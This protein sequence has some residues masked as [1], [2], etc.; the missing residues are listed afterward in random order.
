[1]QHITRK[2]IFIDDYLEKE[3]INLLSKTY[4]IKNGHKSFSEVETEN[5][6]LF[7]FFLRAYSYISVKKNISNI[8]KILDEDLA[9]FLHKELMLDNVFLFNETLVKVFAFIEGNTTINIIQNWKYIYLKRVSNIHGIKDAKLNSN[10]SIINKLIQNYKDRADKEL[11]KYNKKAKYRNEEYLYLIFSYIN[12][13]FNI[14]VLEP[15][16]SEYISYKIANKKISVTQEYEE[17]HKLFVMHNAKL[18]EIDIENE[19]ELRFQEV[20]PFLSRIHRQYEINGNIIDILGFDDR[21]GDIYIIEIKNKN[22]PKDLLFQLKNYK[23]AISKEFKN[24][25]IKLISVTPKLEQDYIRELNEIDVEMYFFKKEE[26][27][28]IF[29]KY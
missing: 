4:D 11:K 5:N 3:Y 21:E 13:D 28:I 14:K 2:D 10:Y 18:L 17:Y 26:G 22:K 12:Q 25:K 15:P 29:E 19:I 20:F 24:R 8:N 23:N 9:L 16:I 7:I 27:K 1:M 6:L